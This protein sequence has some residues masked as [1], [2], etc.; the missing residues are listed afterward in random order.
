MPE[1]QTGFERIYLLAEPFVPVLPRHVRARLRGIVQSAAVGD[2]PVK[3]LDVGGR[4]SHY[5]IGVDADV[6]VSDIPR[7]TEIQRQLHLGVDS[8]VANAVRSRRSNVAHLVYDDMTSSAFQDASFDCVVSIEVLEHV[9]RDRDFLQEV[10]RVLRPGGVFLM[11]TPNG[12]YVPN[13]NPD[14][15][16]HYKRDQE[17][18]HAGRKT[19]D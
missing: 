18:E 15:C 6:T 12:D 13:N 7:T 16:R 14:H 19:G 1:L 2:A 17:G 11:T 8:N 3:L 9:P 4:K 10:H 5:T